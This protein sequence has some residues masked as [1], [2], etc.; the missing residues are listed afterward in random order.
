MTIGSFIFAKRP[1]KESDIQHEAIH[2]EQCKETL[3]LGFYILY[4]LMFL[5]ELMRCTIDSQRGTRADGVKRNIWKRAYN[6]I[7][8]EREAYMNDE[9]QFY[10]EFRPH[11]AWLL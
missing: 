6:S 5:W 8:F 10:L 7:A 2:W 9:V 4:V 1:L 11:Y 3:I